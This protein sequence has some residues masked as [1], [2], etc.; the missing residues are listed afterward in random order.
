[1]E[2]VQGAW[3]SHPTFAPIEAVTSSRSYP[4][5]MRAGPSDKVIANAF[6]RLKRLYRDLTAD[7]AS[8]I[9]IGSPLHVIGLSLEKIRTYRSS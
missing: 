2:F 1:M 8:I 7:S 3:A 4:E 6:P 9:V 5:Q